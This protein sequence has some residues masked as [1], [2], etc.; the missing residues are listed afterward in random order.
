MKVGQRN[1]FPVVD[2]DSLRSL[3]ARVA[4][5]SQ[6]YFVLFDTEMESDV[7]SG[8]VVVY[9]PLLGGGSSGSSASN[10]RSS[11]TVIFPPYSF[12]HTKS[13]GVRSANSVFYG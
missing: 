4:Y 10:S 9:L 5:A 12:Q 8:L 11:V 1:S 6:T 13:V 2:G 7:N 3:F